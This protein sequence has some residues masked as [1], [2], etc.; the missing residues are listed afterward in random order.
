MHKLITATVLA[1]AAALPAQAMLVNDAALIPAPSASIDFEAYDGYFPS[2][3]EA[4]SDDVT[5]T[6]DTDSQLGAFIADLGMNGIWGA[7]NKFVA[8]EFF[9]ELRFTFADGLL[10]QGAGAFVNHY[11]DDVLPFAVEV[12]A[13]GE[14]NEIIETH[15]LA[16]DTAEDSVNAGLFVGIVRDAADIRS[17]SFKGVT[18]L[19]DFTHAVPVPE[20]ETWAMMFAGLLAMG[21]MVRRRSRG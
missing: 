9:G 15:R 8:T 6:G 10:S 21:A 5:F 1:A 3:P 19:D 14:N 17:I 7:G 11:A 12:S 13:Y 2:G 20:P 16:I 18:V 4:V